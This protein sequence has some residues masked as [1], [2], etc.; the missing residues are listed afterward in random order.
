MSQLLQF[1]GIYWG[2]SYGQPKMPTFANQVQDNVTPVL[3]GAVW[4]SLSFQKFS[5]WYNAHC[6]VVLFWMLGFVGSLI[7][8]GGFD[9][10]IRLKIMP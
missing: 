4:P 2:A 3:K 8:Q 10:S 6:G 1:D 7:V 5:R 9:S